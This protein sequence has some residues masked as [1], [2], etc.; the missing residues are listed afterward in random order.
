VRSDLF[1]SVEQMAAADPRFIEIDVSFHRDLLFDELLPDDYPG[2]GPSDFPD[3]LRWKVVVALDTGQVTDWPGYETEETIEL[4][5]PG[6]SSTYTLLDENH[7]FLARRVDTVPQQL[8]P[9][10]RDYLRFDITAT[11]E[12]T[13]WNLD[14]TLDEF[15]EGA[16]ASGAS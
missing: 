11:G 10:R 8:L 3:Y 4:E 14:Y 5:E 1:D 15:V 12:I 9:G 6:A 7:Q 2:I 16:G 13:N